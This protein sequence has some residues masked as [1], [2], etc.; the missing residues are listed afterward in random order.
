ML[1]ALYVAR[2]Q[3]CISLHTGKGSLN[4]LTLLTA[5]LNT[6]Q[7]SFKIDDIKRSK[8]SFFNL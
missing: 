1:S 7:T 3:I 2:E 8:S 4:V 6:D 5:L